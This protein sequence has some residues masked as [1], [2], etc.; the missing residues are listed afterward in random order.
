MPQN[1]A[2]ILQRIEQFL[3]PPRCAFCGTRCEPQEAGICM[4]CL[5]DMPWRTQL[6]SK[7]APIELTVAPFDYA[8]PVDAALKALKFRRR[9]DYVAVFAEILWRV[10]PA[11]P[12]DIDAV[13]PVPLHW[14]R[15]AMRGFNQATELSRLL[16]ARTG[17]PILSNVVRNRSTTF[18]SG[19]AAAERRRNLRHAFTVQGR[20]RAQ[21]VLIV[22]DVI[23][24]G[25]TSNE[26]AR[27]AI[28]AGAKKVSVLAVA[29]SAVVSSK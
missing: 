22:D 1:N 10:S 15:H 21:H 7:E 6:T 25:A 8:F 2:V 5:D 26:L 11:L 9:L 16:C 24:T 23:T 29:R 14:R 28:A 17:L 4:G 3:L 13:L 19:L 12:Q 18:Q 27:Q 20:C